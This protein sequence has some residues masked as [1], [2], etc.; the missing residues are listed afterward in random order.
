M[1]A[2]DASVGRRRAKNWSPRSMVASNVINTA[3]VTNG[4]F[5]GEQPHRAHTRFSSAQAGFP[6]PIGRV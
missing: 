1:G 3:T 4:D 2:P 6:P 5:H